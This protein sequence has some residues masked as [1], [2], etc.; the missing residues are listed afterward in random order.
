MRR[1]LRLW[2][3]AVV[4]LG[5]VLAG[6]ARADVLNGACGNTARVFSP[7]GDGSNYYYAGNGGF[8]N[9]SDGW[10]LSGGASVVPGNESSYLHSRSDSHALSVPDGGSASIQLCYGLSYPALRFF[11][12]SNDG[13]TVH[14]SVTT[15]NWLGVVSTLDGG[16]FQPGSDWAPSPKLSTLLSALIAPFGA[17]SMALHI[18]VSNGTAQIDDLYVDPLVQRS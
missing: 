7:W 2:L 3:V 18:D 13:A 11:A 6:S 14:V 12:R 4:A 5:A 17:K 8:E 9:G 15:Q 16:T 1:V 10:S